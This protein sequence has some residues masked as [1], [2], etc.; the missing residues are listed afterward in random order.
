[1]PFTVLKRY[2]RGLETGFKWEPA[3][4]T[5]RID[6]PVRRTSTVC[7]SDPEPNLHPAP[8][9]MEPAGHPPRKIAKRKHPRPNESSPLLDERVQCADRAQRPVSTPSR[10]RQSW[11]VTHI[12]K[13][14]R[15]QNAKPLASVHPK[16]RALVNGC[17]WIG[18]SRIP[19]TPKYYSS[20]RGMLP[21]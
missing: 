18:L 17:A 11:W 7:G 5:R 8:R 21:P 15:G 9:G 2:S 16:P 14:L 6:P 1:V 19:C 3:A 10:G 13:A 4:P 20:S 12:G